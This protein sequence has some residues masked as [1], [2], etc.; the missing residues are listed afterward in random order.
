MQ[1]N[2]HHGNVTSQTEEFINQIP[3]LM[4]QIATLSQNLMPNSHT[5]IRSDSR[6]ANSLQMIS[7]FSGVALSLYTLAQTLDT[8]M[9]EF[10][11]FET[12]TV[13]EFQSA[14]NS[15]RSSISALRENISGE[16]PRSNRSLNFHNA[17]SQQGSPLTE[18]LDSLSQILD[19]LATHVSTAAN[20]SSASLQR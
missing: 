19:T 6:L 1:N 17:P 2:N 13:A 5:D 16:Q 7:D 12:E 15:A 3:G 18:S 9:T 4:A 14:I 8:Q 20:D 10:S 11:R